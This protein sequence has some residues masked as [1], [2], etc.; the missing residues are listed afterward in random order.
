[1]DDFDCDVYWSCFRGEATFK[2]CPD[3][4]GFDPARVRFDEPCDYLFKVNCTGREGLGEPQGTGV[5]ERKNGIFPHEDADT[6][7]QYYTCENNEPTKSTCPPGLHFRL[8]ELVCDWPAA[9]NRGACGAK[10]SIGNFTCDPE[11]EYFTPAKQ[12]IQHP[13]FAHNDCRKFYVCKNGIDPAISSCDYG[14]VYSIDDATCDIPAN[15]P[16]CATY[17]DEEEA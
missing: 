16:D 1:M 12:K 17:Y 3:G 6:C 8:D 15:V 14:L 13:T 9:A 2:E 10:K 4:F 5:C 11:I 7:D